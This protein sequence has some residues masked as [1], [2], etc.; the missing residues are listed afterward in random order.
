LILC[1]VVAGCGSNQSNAPATPASVSASSANGLQVQVASSDLAVGRNR[2]TFGL[3]DNNRPVSTGEPTVTFYFIARNNRATA[4]AQI[5]ARFN[6]FASGLAD[7]SANSAAIEIKGVYVGYAT[8]DRAGTW[9]IEVRIRYRGR[10]RVVRSQQFI[11]L[12]HSYTPAVGSP[13][14][15]S[16]NP[17]IAQL[18]AAKLDSGNPPDDMHR[19]S[20]AQALVLHKPLVV[21]FATAAYCTSR[22]CG[23][24]IQVI[25]QL[26]RRYRSRV[27][28]VHI[29]IY[30]NARPPQFAPTVLQWRLQT[31]PWVFVVN[32]SGR[33]AAKFEGPTP[34]SE[35]AP[36]INSTL[37]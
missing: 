24:E 13:A 2:F 8:F 6:Y 17:T 34:G 31:E 12:P 36:T 21:L 37:T 7:T 4:I 35:I 26:E 32:R 22:L 28:F 9:G 18:P 30:N 11:V 3:I 23:P 16:H 5:H 19:L 1:F 10:I 14:P 15:R 27:N 25:Q 20:I 29:E 33:I